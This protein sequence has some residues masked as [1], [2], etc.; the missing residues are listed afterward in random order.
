M[1]GIGG[2]FGNVGMV[3]SG[4]DVGFGRVGMVGK[5]GIDGTV[6]CSRWRALKLMFTVEKIRATMR[7]KLFK[8]AILVN[9]E[10]NFVL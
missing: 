8:E 10:R 6:V 1:V 4:K 5:V 9:K 2:I 3:G 7:A